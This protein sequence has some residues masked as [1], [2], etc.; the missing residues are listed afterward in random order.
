MDKKQNLA[1]L[2][3]EVM[4]WMKTTGAD[5]KAAANK[6]NMSRTSLSNLLG[7]FNK[8]PPDLIDMIKNGKIT[9]SA[10]KLL[11]GV[12]FCPNLYSEVLEMAIKKRPYSYMEAHVR[13]IR[14]LQ[15][16]SDLDSL[17]KGIDGEGI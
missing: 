9:Y 12:R 8:M 10:A 16:K 13:R 7:V 15:D 6:F 5:Q 17:R 11:K 3:E 14:A 1:F 4:T 2:A